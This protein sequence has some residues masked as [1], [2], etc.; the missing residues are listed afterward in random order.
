[1]KHKAISPCVFGEIIM[2]LDSTITTNF[3]QYVSLIENPIIFEMSLDDSATSQN[4]KSML[5][6][7]QTI[8]HQQKPNMISI[9]E[10]KL[11]R[12]P[13]FHILNPI[14][15]RFVSFAGLPLGHEF[16]SFVLALLQISGRKP[17][18]SEE[19]IQ[20]IQNIQ[21][22]IHFETYV[23]LSCHNCPDVVQALNMMSVLNPNITHEMIEGG[24]F[25]QE[26]EEKQIMSVPSIFMNGQ[27][28][29]SGR[30]SI[31]EILS[32][33]QPQSQQAVEHQTLFDV[34]IIGGGPAGGSAAIYSARKGLKTAIIA[35]RFGGQVLDTMSIENYISI[36]Q[37][38]GPSFVK[39]LEEHVKHY[40]VDIFQS[41]KVVKLEKN[42]TFLI[43]LENGST[44]QSKTV[45]VATG[46]RWRELN[47]PGE[48]EF[49]NK[50][51]AYCPHCDGPLFKN[52]TVAVVGG[53]N[54]GVEAA[55]DLAG[56]V[57]NVIL[58]EFAPQLKADKIL[59]NKLQSLSNVQII[60]NAQTKSI[61]G[62]AKVE[63]LS[64]FDRSKNQEHII[65][66]DGV[67]IQIGL[68][69]NTQWL[70]EEIQ[71]SSFGEIVINEH[72]QTNIPGL[73]AAGDCTTIPYKQI[74]ISTGEGA[75]ASLSAFDYLVRNF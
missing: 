4:M 26:I 62:K 22:K 64:Y 60:C 65:F 53:G 11:E 7:I 37:T 49:K 58:L 67:F 28:W 56:I 1:M 69:P 3:Q 12:T 13:S 27:F 45:I 16:T 48:Q 18:L 15:S 10:K 39:A 24:V 41:Q 46:A 31:E 61:Q 20:Q 40:D 21:Q 50:G 34:L 70:G 75:K 6:E 54:S 59:Q 35:E 43:T 5:E 66:L 8:V 74:I 36:S 30:M 42:E 73:F 47:I 51:V 2:F 57:K 68:I 33:I 23:S 19:V 17:K 44:L 29:N 14:T 63:Q 32:K 71:K 55:I 72:N 38:N 52:K 25:P 9:Q